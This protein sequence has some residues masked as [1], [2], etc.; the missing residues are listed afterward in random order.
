[1]SL[2]FII[3]ARHTKSQYPCLLCDTIWNK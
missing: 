2:K 1:M 3:V